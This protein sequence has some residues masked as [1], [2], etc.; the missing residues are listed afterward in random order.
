M[1]QSNKRNKECFA[2]GPFFGVSSTLSPPLPSAEIGRIYLLHRS[3]K[4]EERMARKVV[5]GGLV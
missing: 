3:E 4:D 1:A 5:S 2:I